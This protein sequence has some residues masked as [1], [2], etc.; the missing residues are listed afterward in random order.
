M[1]ANIHSIP[2]QLNHSKVETLMHLTIRCCSYIACCIVHTTMADAKKINQ[3]SFDQHLAPEAAPYEASY[4]ARQQLQQFTS[5]TTIQIKIPTIIRAGLKNAI[6][7][8][9]IA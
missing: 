5:E 6:N 3:C 8:L 7:I 4:V 9:L 2:G 1:L